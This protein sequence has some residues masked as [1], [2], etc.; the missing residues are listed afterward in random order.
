MSVMQPINPEILRRQVMADCG[1]GLSDLLS[2]S[3]ASRVVFARAI[4]CAVLRQHT[5]LSLPEIN[6]VIRSTTS[7]H[8]VVVDAIKRVRAGGHDADAQLLTG[9][10]VTALDYAGYCAIRARE[11]SQATPARSASCLTTE[12]AA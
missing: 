6:R 4:I 9:L 5:D 8:A 12:V 11:A 3:R 10:D 1:I 2:G 7:R